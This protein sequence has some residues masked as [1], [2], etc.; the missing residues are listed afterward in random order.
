MRNFKIIA[1]VICFRQVLHEVQPR[2]AEARARQAQG[3]KELWVMGTPASCWVRW[4][5]GGGR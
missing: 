1:C 2:P 5:N 3:G 4:W